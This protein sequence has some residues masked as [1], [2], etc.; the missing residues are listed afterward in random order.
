MR[1]PRGVKHNTDERAGI[2]RGEKQVQHTAGLQ[3]GTRTTS[4]AAR[5]TD[6]GA[7]AG[8]HKVQTGLARQAGATPGAPREPRVQDAGA[9][10]G[11]ARCQD[12]KKAGTAPGL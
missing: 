12:K 6:R 4:N 5:I 3:A 7:R 2:G 1:T 11:S 8:S 10:R 9:R